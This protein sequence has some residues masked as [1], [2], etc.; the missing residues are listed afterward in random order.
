VNRRV[1]I[2]NEQIADRCSRIERIIDLKGKQAVRAGVIPQDRL[3]AIQQGCPD[4]PSPQIGDVI[5][6][7]GQDY[8]ID[9]FASDGV[10]LTRTSRGEERR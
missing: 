3:D 4:E 6:W 8:R 9:M 1:K 5:N 2:T 10:I 7:D